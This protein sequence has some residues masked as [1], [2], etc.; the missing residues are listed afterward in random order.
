MKKKTG[1]RPFAW[2]PR[3]GEEYAN[4]ARFHV[5][6]LMTRKKLPISGGLKCAAPRT[7][8]KFITGR[9]DMTITM[10]E[11]IAEELGSTLPAMFRPR[12]PHA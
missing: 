12:P 1:P 11:N 6:R 3:E 7:L 5:H 10:L 2:R 4:R 8:H 9:S